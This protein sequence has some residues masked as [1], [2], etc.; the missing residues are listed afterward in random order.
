MDQ[1]LQIAGTV[2]AV[3]LLLAAWRECR[4]ARRIVAVGGLDADI[5]EEHGCV[6]LQF[7]GSRYGIVR[8]AVA[9]TGFFMVGPKTRKQAFATRNIV[10]IRGSSEVDYQQ[11]R[12]RDRL[13]IMLDEG[14][15][16][17]VFDR[18][19]RRGVASFYRT[20][21]IRQLGGQGSNEHAHC[22]TVRTRGSVVRV[23]GD[24]GSQWLEYPVIAAAPRS[25]RRSGQSPLTDLPED[26]IELV[27]IRPD[28]YQRARDVAAKR[29][30]AALR[31]WLMRRNPNPIT[32][33]A[34]FVTKYTLP[35]AALVVLG[36][37]YSGSTDISAVL[38]VVALPPVL[39]SL[40]LLRF[41]ALDALKQYLRRRIQ[42]GDQSDEATN[43]PATETILQTIP[44]R[45]EAHPP[46][47]VWTGAT[48]H[49]MSAG[50]R[51]NATDA[52]SMITDAW[53]QFSYGYGSLFKHP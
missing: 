42:S 33:A 32:A 1:L 4:S 35:P 5:Y 3:Q 49:C 10:A 18:S 24:A 26:A 23:A 29:R 13:R 34:H 43:P 9:V 39:I 37:L 21:A 15:H 28:T 25:T 27:A 40:L 14:E 41:V 36:A 31:S 50:R 19:M 17:K 12:P 6:P 53:H 2:A 46:P 30:D 22:V 51:I 47:E 44:L 11:I 48:A 38:F 8:A 7:A 20:V 52:R 45:H 16:P